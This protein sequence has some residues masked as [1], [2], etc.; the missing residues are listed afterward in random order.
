MFKSKKSNVF[1]LHEVLKVDSKQV[2]SQ[3]AFLH[4]RIFQEIV[5]IRHI[6]TGLQPP[7]A[8]Q[9]VFTGWTCSTSST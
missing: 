8:V 5:S 2:F 9:E 1:L 6:I 4:F 3:I 7:E